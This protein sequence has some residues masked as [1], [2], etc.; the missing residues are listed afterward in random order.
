MLEQQ[1][2]PKFSKD[3]AVIDRANES[4]HVKDPKFQDF[5]ESTQEQPKTNSPIPAGPS[6][7]HPVSPSQCSECRSRATASN[8][9]ADHSSQ[10]LEST[11]QDIKTIIDSIEIIRI[12][13]MQMEELYSLHLKHNNSNSNSEINNTE[14]AEI[15]NKIEFK[16]NYETILNTNYEHCTDPIRE[17][18]SDKDEM[19]IMEKIEDVRIT[20]SIINKIPKPISNIT[21]FCSNTDEELPTLVSDSDSDSDS[22]DDTDNNKNTSIKNK[23]CDIQTMKNIMEHCPELEPLKE[24]KYIFYLKTKIKCS[25]FNIDL[26]TKSNMQYGTLIKNTKARIKKI[27]IVVNNELLNTYKLNYRNKISYIARYIDTNNIEINKN[28]NYLIFEIDI[29]KFKENLQ[30]KNCN[31]N[32]NIKNEK[33]K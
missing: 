33:L 29:N 26:L 6:E 10:L 22:D 28:E 3:L 2:P 1:V 23:N 7:S 30:A 11:Y 15:D 17:S 16:N 18:E 9:M 25:T 8:Y 13:M 4:L 24:H 20:D 19:K 21:K 12:K 14:N 32:T 27:A 5:S 31:I